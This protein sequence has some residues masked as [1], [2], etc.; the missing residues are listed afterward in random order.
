MAAGVDEKIDCFSMVHGPWINVNA[1]IRYLDTAAGEYRNITTKIGEPA[2]KDA[3]RAFLPAFEKHL[4]EKGWFEITYLAFDEKPEK[5]MRVIYDYLAG[6]APWFKV[7][8]AGG[9]PGDERKRSD[10]VILHVND[11]LEEKAWEESRPLVELMRAEGRY[12]SFYT[13]CEPYRPNVFLFSELRDARLLPW[14]APK[15]NLSG[16]LR[17][18]VAAF[19][20]DVW[21][22]PNYKWHS[23]DMYFVYPGP[24]GPLDGMRWE[25]FRQGLQDCEALRI[26]REMAQKAGRA[27]LLEKLDRAV[28]EATILNSCAEIPLVSVARDMVNEVIRELGG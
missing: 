1:G 20:E 23:G 21:T 2:W 13:A 6:T 25:V 5:E 22:Q 15:Y 9:Y 12:I 19:P 17:W 4:K 7:S 3:W 18:A 26:A 27:D 16:Y 11:L 24:D 28:G 8:I 10:E 14:L